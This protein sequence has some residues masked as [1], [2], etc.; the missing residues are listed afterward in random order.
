MLV[1]YRDASYGSANAP[2]ATTPDLPSAG[3]KGGLLLVDSHFDPLRHRGA[4]AEHYADDEHDPQHVKNFPVRVQVSDN[5]FTTWGTYAVRDCF[6]EPGK[7]ELVYCTRYGR[8]GPMSSFSDALGWYPG[9]EA[10]GDS[11]TFRDQDASVVIPS[12][13]NQPY[14]TRVV[15]QNGDPVP[16][17]Y[18]TKLLDGRVVL[19]SGNP[20][21]EGKQLG[22]TLSV[23][24]AAARNRSATIHVTAATPDGS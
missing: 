21:D 23:V 9:I 2:T 16:S 7:L 24:K 22:V 17:L 20:G 15:D 18:G 11:F 5:A 12:R 19:G 3:S 10:R 8:R 6:I 13:G 14:S 4:P 1:W